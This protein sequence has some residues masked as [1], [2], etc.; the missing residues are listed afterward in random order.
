MAA[1]TPAKGNALPA[2]VFAIWGATFASP[3]PKPNSI[4]SSLTTVPAKFAA[5]AELLTVKIPAALKAATS[6]LVNFLLVL[7]LISLTLTVTFVVLS[8][9]L[10]ELE[11]VEFS[12][13]MSAKRLSPA[14]ADSLKAISLACCFTILLASFIFKFASATAVALSP[15]FIVNSSVRCWLEAISKL[16]LDDINS[17]LVFKLLES[18][19]NA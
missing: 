2:R 15:C 6:F 14:F 4:S 16:A 18:I 13:T 9:I 19:L 5:S 11:I 17:L 7:G 1:K 10:G 8:L 3:A 12:A